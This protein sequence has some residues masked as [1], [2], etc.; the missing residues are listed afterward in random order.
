MQKKIRKN[1][2]EKIGFYIEDYTDSKKGYNVDDLK[3]DIKSGNIQ[4]IK[5]E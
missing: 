4:I 1:L 2:R 5:E 3:K